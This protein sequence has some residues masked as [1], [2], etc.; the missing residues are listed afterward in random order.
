M[1]EVLV[2]TIKV[3][4]EFTTEQWAELLLRSENKKNIEFS[5]TVDTSK[6]KRQKAI[7]ERN[8]QIK[9]DKKRRAHLERE[10]AFKLTP[11]EAVVIKT[12]NE[13][14]FISYA[15][16]NRATESRNYP[17]AINTIDERQAKIIRKAMREVGK[18][19][20]LEEM[21]RYFICCLAGKHIW[22]R[23]NHG[24]KNVIGFLW[25]MIVLEDD[26]KLPW[27]A[28]A[29]EAEVIDDDPRVTALLAD[30][31]AIK[32]LGQNS[33]GLTKEDDEYIKF[34]KFRKQL[35]KRMTSTSYQAAAK[36]VFEALEQRYE[37]VL[38]AHLCSKTTWKVIVPQFIN[39]Q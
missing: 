33:F 27:W 25:K 36:I 22:D 23:S 29:R 39:R 19:K 11:D 21:N 31:Y 8:V 37:F 14:K 2:G 10:S 5:L 3:T 24:Y 18:G 6:L 32:F 12:W 16:N 34:L 4:F 20:L 13:S 15:G 38:P 35:K 30:L 9:K 28:N 7:V 26:K 1:L 17:L